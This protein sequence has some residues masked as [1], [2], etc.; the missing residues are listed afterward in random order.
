MS[1]AKPWHESDEF[2]ALRER[3]MFGPDAWERAPGEVERILAL[4]CVKPGSDVLDLCCGPGRHS[5]ELARRGFAVT[6]VDRTTAYLQRAERTARAEELPIRFVEADMRSFRRPDAFDAA[7]SMF[8][9][10]GYF[11][12]SADD[13]KVLA[14][15]HASLRPGGRLLM[16]MMGKEVL[17]R[18][19]NPRH[20]VEAD[21][22]LLLVERS[23]DRDWTWLRNHEIYIVG[24]E[25]HELDLDHRI[26]SAGE[27][28][29]LLE[30]AAFCDVTFHG[31]LSGAAYDLTARRLIAVAS[32][33]T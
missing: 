33:P 32:K 30:S 13:G 3:F 17:A 10:F 24:G 6:G 27:L 21:G 23:V 19:F 18:R 12:D 22:A 15:L 9:S 26:Y 25:R 11:E 4:L 20:W 1:G 28:R 29:L 7:I 14:N 5:L 8:T 16:E 31:D 2:W